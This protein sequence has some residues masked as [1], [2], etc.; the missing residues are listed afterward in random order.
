MYYTIVFN[1]MAIVYFTTQV[2]VSMPFSWWNGPFII[3]EI[4]VYIWKHHLSWS[5]LS[6]IN[7]D[8]LT[9]FTTHFHASNFSICLISPLYWKWVGP[10]ICQYYNLSF[11]WSLSHLHL[12]N[13]WYGYFYINHLIGF[14]FFLISLLWSRLYIVT[15]FI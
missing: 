9:F 15:L 8:K 5:L 12:N 14:F 13:Y 1:N 3:M 6:V 10:Y 4:T 2:V 7:L 11:N